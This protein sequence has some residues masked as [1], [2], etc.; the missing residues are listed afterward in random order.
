MPE[1]DFLEGQRIITE[2]QLDF[3]RENIERSAFEELS[4]DDDED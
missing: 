3:F 2:K 1:S 4:D